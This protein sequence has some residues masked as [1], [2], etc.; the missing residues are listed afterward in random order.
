LPAGEFAD[1]NCCPGKQQNEEHEIV[2]HTIAHRFAKSVP[3]DGANAQ[4]RAALDSS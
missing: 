3:R 4:D 1:E 2:E